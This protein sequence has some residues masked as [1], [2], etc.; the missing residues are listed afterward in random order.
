MFSYYTVVCRHVAIPGYQKMML[1]ILKK[2]REC[3]G[4]R[5]MELTTFIGNHF[6]LSEE[7]KI[8]RLSS[9]QLVVYNRVSW[10]AWYL[11]KANLIDKKRDVTK[12]GSEIISK[13]W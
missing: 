8:E 2:L 12:L 13:D 10:S 4:L 1:P 5:N 9:E 3:P 7:E 6:N 11:Q